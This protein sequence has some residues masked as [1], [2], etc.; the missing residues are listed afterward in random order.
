MIDGKVDATKT[1][2]RHISIADRNTVYGNMTCQQ[3]CKTTLTNKGDLRDI[4]NQ[5]CM[6]GVGYENNL[7][8]SLDHD[9]CSRLIRDSLDRFGE[10]I[11]CVCG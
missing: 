10:T 7:I 5:N 6:F 4:T 11:A 1:T 3:L 9:M 8:K 2:V